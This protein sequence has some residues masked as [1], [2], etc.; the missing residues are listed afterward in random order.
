MPVVHDSDAISMGADVNDHPYGGDSLDVTPTGP[1]FNF[2]GI[3]PNGIATQ[4]Y[5]IVIVN[6]SAADAFTIKHDSVSSAAGNRFFFSDN[7]DHALNPQE[8]VWG[9]RREDVAGRVGWWMQF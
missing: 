5:E 6:E 2:T 8:Q 9:I 4:G 7:L 1:G 3:D